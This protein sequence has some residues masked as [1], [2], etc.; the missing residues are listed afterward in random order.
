MG[1]DLTSD[2]VLVRTWCLRLTIP[3]L[4]C[5]PTA[6]QRIPPASALFIRSVL[7]STR[8]ASMILHAWRP[9]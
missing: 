2:L 3:D 6:A 9:V 1:D 8:S 7:N 4:L 5:P